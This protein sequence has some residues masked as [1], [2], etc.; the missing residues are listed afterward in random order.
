[1]ELARGIEPSNRRR[2]GSEACLPAPAEG[3]S[4]LACSPRRGHIPFGT[5]GW[6]FERRTCSRYLSA[7]DNEE[8]LRLVRRRPTRSAVWSW[9]EESN[10]QPAVYKTAALPIEL[11]QPAGGHPPWISKLPHSINSLERLSRN[12]LLGQAGYFRRVGLSLT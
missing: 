3:A 1:M 7:A 11:R 9:R 2:V 5:P 8:R 6:R 10:L 12:L 4:P